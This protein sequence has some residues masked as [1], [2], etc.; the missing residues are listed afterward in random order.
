MAFTDVQGGISWVPVE[1]ESREGFYT[2]VKHDQ[3]PNSSRV[4]T[5]TTKEGESIIFWGSTVLDNKL[6]DNVAINDYIQVTFLGH[7]PMKNNPQK[8]YKNWNVGIDK[9]VVMES[10]ATESPIA[11]S[12]PQTQGMASPAPTA[13]P[14]NVSVED[15]LPF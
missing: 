13:A 12:T 10:K 5:L 4:H 3:G 14:D 11:N 6:A 15:D 2:D 7:K 1:N 9:S 8:T